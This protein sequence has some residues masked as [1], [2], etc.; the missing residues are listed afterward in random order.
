[1]I[2]LVCR[3]APR[4]SAQPQCADAFDASLQGCH[5]VA[6]AAIKQ[7]CGCRGTTALQTSAFGSGIFLFHDFMFF[8]ADLRLNR[9]F[10]LFLRN[11]LN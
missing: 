8:R 11:Q 5:A 7:C 3:D 1:M 2:A 9:K 4:A 6:A 10:V